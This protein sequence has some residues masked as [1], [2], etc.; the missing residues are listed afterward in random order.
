MTAMMTVGAEETK[1]I[2]VELFCEKAGTEMPSEADGKL[3]GSANGLISETGE[4]D[5]D[6]TGE[7][8]SATEGRKASE[9]T[10]TPEAVRGFDFGNLIEKK[11]SIKEKS[12]TQQKRLRRTESAAFL[13]T[14]I[15]KQSAVKGKRIGTEK[16]FLRGIRIGDNLLCG[17]LNRIE[18]NLIQFML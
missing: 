5:S 10:K 12:R 7:Y 17:I 14:F 18:R 4:S 6:R 16:V 15:V 3:D 1:L 13:Q 8:N 2:G 9:M 11:L